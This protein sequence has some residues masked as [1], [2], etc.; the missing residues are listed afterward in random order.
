MLLC[1]FVCSFT[2]NHSHYQKNTHYSESYFSF[3]GGKETAKDVEKIDDTISSIIWLITA[4][5]HFRACNLQYTRSCTFLNYRFVAT[6]TKDEVQIQTQQN[7][8]LTALKLYRTCK[9]RKTNALPVSL[10]IEQLWVSITQ[11][12]SCA[13]SQF[14]IFIT[15][16]IRMVTSGRK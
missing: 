16:I 1:G 2:Q 5:M 3:G 8:Y 4:T 10:V 12:Q 14:G 15:T 11:Y 9:S 13:C 6:N 7:T